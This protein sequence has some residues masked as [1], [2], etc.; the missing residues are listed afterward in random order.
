MSA[1]LREIEKEIDVHLTR[2][3]AYVGCGMMTDDDLGEWLT[4]YFKKT[5]KVNDW[6][7][8]YMYAIKSEKN[9]LSL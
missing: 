7:S 3:C 6:L 1:I 9:G 4:D 5:C 2:L 8:L